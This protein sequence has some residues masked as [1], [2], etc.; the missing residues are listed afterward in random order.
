MLLL[1]RIDE[2]ATVSV[3]GDLVVNR[4]VLAAAVRNTT[5]FRGVTCD[6]T[7]EANGDRAPELADLTPCDPVGQPVIWGDNNCSGSADPID[8]LLTLRFD[9]GLPTNTGDCPAFGASV[10]VE[11]TVGRVPAAGPQ[12]GDTNLMWGDID[13]TLAINP[14]DSLKLLRFDAGLPV[15]Q[16]AGC[17]LLGANVAVVPLP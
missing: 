2:V 17:S 14:I 7:I 6:I 9:A 8:S 12:G 10:H 15:S 4:S 11:V 13:C 16:E 5:D 1:T 3:E